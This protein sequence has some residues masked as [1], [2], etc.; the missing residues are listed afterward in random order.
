MISRNIISEL[1][2]K[3]TRGNDW[4]LSE[5]A[6]INEYQL[7]KLEPTIGIKVTVRDIRKRTK[8]RLSPVNQIEV[9]HRGTGRE[10]DATKKG[11]YL[12]RRLKTNGSR[13]GRPVLPI[14]CG[15]IQSG[16]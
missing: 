16:V 7:T 5:W 3:W 15:F 6:E 8:G 14:P 10:H 12:I 4:N 2:L 13:S 1:I 11:N 9:S